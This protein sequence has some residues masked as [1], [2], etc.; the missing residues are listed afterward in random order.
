MPRRSGSGGSW[1]APV[2]SEGAEAMDSRRTAVALRCVARAFGFLFFAIGCAC[3]PL[4]KGGAA[5]ETSA[6]GPEGRR[7]GHDFLALV[8]GA[9]S[10]PLTFTRDRPLPSSLAFGPFHFN[11]WLFHAPRTLWSP[12]ARLFVLDE[13]GP[14]ELDRHGGFWPY[15]ERIYAGPG[16]TLT[17]VRESCLE[18]FRLAFDGVPFTVVSCGEPGAQAELAGL[19][20]RLLG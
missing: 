13:V 4:G 16:H 20:R 14:L 5:A 12:A 11:R 18:R 6:H 3:I 7:E 1:F 10:A 17:V 9:W 8:D 19:L 2:E 15:L